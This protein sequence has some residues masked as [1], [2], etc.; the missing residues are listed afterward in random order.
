MIIN[1]CFLDQHNSIITGETTLGQKIRSAGKRHLWDE[2]AGGAFDTVVIHYISAVNKGVKNRFGFGAV[3]SVFCEYGVSS[4][5]LINRRGKV[6]GLVPVEKKAWHCGGSI[7]PAPDR[8]TG[9]NDFSVGIELLA[10][11][12]S[13]YT[14]AQY[15][16]LTA[17]C[18]CLES[19]AGKKMNYLGHSDVAG[20]EAVRMGLRKE[21]KTD[22]GPLF[23]WGAFNLEMGRQRSDSTAG[24]MVRKRM[25]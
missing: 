11:H 21:V 4:H 8:R 24:K 15:R 10:T 6:F 9:V 16:A 5:F 1:D 22:P 2:R 20:E 14:G 23:D 19:A 3:M 17:L 7:M 12:D 13:G 25:V 18:G